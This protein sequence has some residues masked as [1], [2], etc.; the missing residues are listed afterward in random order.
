M[1]EELISSSSSMSSGSEDENDPHQLTINEHYAKAFQYRKEREELAKLKEK[2]GSDADTDDLNSDD[3]S[4]SDVSEDEDGDE[5]TPALDAAILRTLARIKARDPGIYDADRNV[6]EE[7]HS[8][9]GTLPSAPTRAKKTRSS[10]PV[11]TLREHRLAA[12]LDV[13]SARSSPSPE[14][15]S[16]AP[17]THVAEQ[18]VTLPEHRLAA[19]LDV[20]SPRSSASPEY[21]SPPSLTHVAEQAALRA[22]TIS[23]FHFG[24]DVREADAGDAGE[25]EEEEEEEGGLFTLRE[26][27]RDEVE[28]EEAEYRAYLEREVGPL[29]KILDFGEEGNVKDETEKEDVHVHADET[30]P[31]GKKKKKRG[32]K[33]VEERKE[34]D[35]EFL[36]NYILHRGWID[37]SARRIPTYKEIT[38]GAT[39]HDDPGPSLTPSGA[40]VVADANGDLLEDEDEFDEVAERFES[41]YNFRFEE[42]DAAHISSFPRAVESV[43]RPTEHAE[44]RRAARE[45]R[46]ERK[47]AEKAQRREEVKRL[48]GLKT[49]EMEAKLERIGREG[50]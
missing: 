37:R 2:Y 49:R 10:K 23:A 12:A 31:G 9:S 13:A 5:L 7:E 29:E 22:E 24:L 44:R 33:V 35:K 4:E 48:R 25:E 38:V 14:Y 40:D 46:Q 11:V 41:S 50:G 15:P 30:S 19:S 28:R 16:P 6:F 34:T 8:K 18:V 1:K 43:R 42:P 47:E 26:K 3:D 32:K 39:S 27:T 36:L 20:A 17:L 45:R 21:P